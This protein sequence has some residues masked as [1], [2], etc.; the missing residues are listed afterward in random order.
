MRGDNNQPLPPELDWSNMKDGIFDK[1]QSIEQEKSARGKRIGL[2]LILFSALTLS[3]FF[4]SQNMAEDQDA[5]DYEVVQLPETDMNKSA[6]NNIGRAAPIN[7][8][9]FSGAFLGEENRKPKGKDLLRTDK[10]SEANQDLKKSERAQM[11]TDP[12]LANQHLHETDSQ[13]DLLNTD[14]IG[15]TQRTL[16]TGQKGLMSL[17]ETRRSRLMPQIQEI[18]AFPTNIFDQISLEKANRSIRDS[19]KMD[20]V[21]RPSIGY[22]K[23]PN[24]LILEG[25][26]TFWNE[27]YG[28]S[29][30]KRAQYETPLPSF[31]LQGHYMRSF[32]RDYFVIAGLQYQQL[33]S[34]FQYSNTIQDYTITLEDTIIQ[35]QN[36]LLTGEQNIIRGD[37]EQSVQAERRVLHH[38]QTRLFKV[39]AGIGKMWRFKSFQTDVYLGGALNGLTHNRGRTIGRDAIIDYN[40]PSNSLFQNQLTVEG[41]FGARVHYFLNS[42]VGLTTSF[43]TQKSLTSWSNQAG[44][45]FRPV[46]FSL[47]LGLSYSL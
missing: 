34:R 40:G 5:E 26:M 6:P 20:R 10:E 45:D 11:D 36:N 47:Q 25:G 12:L 8:I 13:N 24:Q 1:I 41:M 4:I 29:Q 44:I 23:S 27:G 32:N 42:N 16:D 18:Q 21:Y 43:Q 17:A 22:G 14:R 2:F 9:E 46:S 35:V 19:Q 37:V 7:Q 33:E 39:S 31:Q 28:N 30:P 3:L 38:N 15:S